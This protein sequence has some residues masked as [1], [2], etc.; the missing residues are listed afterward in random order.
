[1]IPCPVRIDRY[2][3][4][5]F[6]L[7]WLL[8]SD[9]A[10]A[11]RIEQDFHR[12]PRIIEAGAGVNDTARPVGEWTMIAPEYGREDHGEYTAHGIRAPG[13][14]PEI[15]DAGPLARSGDDPETTGSREWILAAVL[16]FSLLAIMMLAILVLYRRA[17]VN[18]DRLRTMFDHA[19]LSLL[20]LDEHN[21]VRVWNRQAERTFLWRSD[22][23]LGKNAFELVIPNQ[24]RGQ[25]EE[26]LE[27]VRRGHTIAHSENI[28]VRKD[29]NRIL[30][31]WINAPFQDRY[32][33]GRYLIAMARDITERRRLEQ[34]LERAAHYDSL[35]FLP[36]RA[37]I[38]EL[39]KQAM[40]IARR[41]RY[42]LAVLF[43][44]LDD[45][46][47]VNDRMG[48]NAGDRVLQVV[49][50][51]LQEGIRQ[52]DH[53]GRL[54]GDEFLMILQNVDGRAGASEVARK[55]R[56]L[57]S[58]PVEL[59]GGHTARITASIGI[60][61]YPEDGAELEALIHQADRAMYRDKEQ[62]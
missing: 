36:N 55:M 16:V 8:C 26:A 44:D 54:A 37:L 60:S 7:G 42:K 45:F 4:P 19:P 35:T 14:L 39:L 27:R 30:C 46:K 6:L 59:S 34:E 2:Y 25:V 5:V 49:G 57:V 29:G 56:E 13:L 23:V 40:A 20:V 17:R 15:S 62:E 10:H 32:N 52:G 58:Q 51:R 12:D 22:E 43:L 38:L 61:L 50:E 48:H 21:R 31:E 41:Q 47:L 24:A 3:L 28:N 33:K 11:Q 18:A 53:A 9:P 1:M